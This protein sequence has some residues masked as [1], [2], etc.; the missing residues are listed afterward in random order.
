MRNSL[1]AAA[2]A[3][4]L[5]LAP[6][7]AQQQE[8][9]KPDQLV[10]G[11]LGAPAVSALEAPAERDGAYVDV[12]EARIFYEASGQGPAMVLLHGYPLSGALFSRVRDALEEDYT[13][14]TID[15]RGYGK[16]EAPAMPASIDIYAEDAIAVLDEIGVTSAIIGGMSMGGPIT[17]SMYEKRPD[18]FA[19]MVLIDTTAGPATPAE[20]GLW[21]GVAEVIAAKGMAPIYPALLPDML[22]GQTRLT[23]PAVGDYLVQIMQQASAEAG[24]GGAIALAERPD[25]TP[26]LSRIEVPTLVLVGQEDALYAMQV[27]YDM[28]TT[29]P[30]GELAIV[31]DASHA[32]VFENPGASAAAIVTWA[33]GTFRT[34][35][36]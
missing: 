25:F 9:P 15:H 27:S 4:A 10:R 2:S 23:E 17:F 12:G 3:A 19:G 24:R 22:S 26:L 21:R 20:A 6:A 5:A 13:V 8:A 29:L 36:R 31:P 33:N 32:A 11:T 30:R 28:A 34:A 16:S 18:L 14:I 7:L 1:L 35:G